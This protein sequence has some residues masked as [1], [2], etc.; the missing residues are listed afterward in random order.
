MSKNDYV[1][2]WSVKLAGK[3]APTG[4]TTHYRGQEVLSPPQNL[5][6]AQ[7]PDDEGYYLL[8][9]D[10]NGD[11]LTDTYHNDIASAMAQAEWEFGV[12]V[13]EWERVT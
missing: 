6:I 8:Y 5:Q 12:K 2:L 11:E 4:R 1:V 13:S 9:L 3:H 7:Y 10:E